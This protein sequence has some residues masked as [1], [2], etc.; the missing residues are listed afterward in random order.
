[1][2]YL[3]GPNIE[4]DGLRKM[5][6]HCQETGHDCAREIRRPG[7]DIDLFRLDSLA[8]K[9]SIRSWHAQAL[10]GQIKEQAFSTFS[11]PPAY[12]EGDCCVSTFRTGREE[13]GK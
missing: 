6:D 9:V 3:T 2:G 10:M 11:M 5:M 12:L 8:V 7:E 4:V 1:M 13:A